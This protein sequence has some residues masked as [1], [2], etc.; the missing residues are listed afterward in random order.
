MMLR[1]PLSNM[2]ETN[3]YPS[4]VPNDQVEADRCRAIPFRG[5]RMRSKQEILEEFTIFSV[6]AGDIGCWLPEQRHD[7]VFARIWMVDEEPL[8]AVRH[9]QLFVLGYEPLVGDGFLRYYW[10][11][12][13]QAAPHIVRE[14]P[15]FSE[16]WLR[17]E[18]MI[19][20]LAHTRPVPD[21]HRRP[22]LL[23]DC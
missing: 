23:Q 14:V 4:S 3:A 1:R 7:E 6:L 13:S 2:S 8:P 9:N 12:T 15:G 22:S 21:L 5:Q 19:V 11:Q 16:D 20:S 10:L 17:S 18:A